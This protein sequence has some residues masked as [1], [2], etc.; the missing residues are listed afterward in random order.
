[1]RIPCVD[2]HTHRRT[3]E[4]VEIVSI[5]TGTELLPEPPFSIGI[6]PWQVRSLESDSACTLA[7][8]KPALLEVEASAAS[9][10]GEIGLDFA[11]PD[12]HALQEQVF[13]CQLHI[14]ESLCK[15]VILHC[16]K[17]FEPLVN[18]L[19]KYP[20]SAAIFHGF[21]GSKQQAARATEAGYYLS[22]GERSL[23]SPK[24]VEA[25]KCT[26]LKYLFL[27]TDESA[28]PISHIYSRVAA[29][30]ALPVHVLKEQLFTNYQTVF[31]HDRTLA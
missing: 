11:Q 27:E 18:T 2:I 14:A 7:D 17:A 23:D 19:A 25:L 31:E 29:L 15:P 26:P 12:N 10:I 1:M 28:L 4:G 13:A 30:L 5:M 24:T 20:L 3:G 8:F 21:I 9:A 22:F 16:V 6:H